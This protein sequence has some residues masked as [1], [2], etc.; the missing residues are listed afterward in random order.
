MARSRP[1]RKPVSLDALVA[2]GTHAITVPEAGK[3]LGISRSSAYDAAA[4]WRDTEGKEGLPTLLLG[5]RRLLV[6]V[7]ALRRML[8]TGAP[9]RS[10]SDGQR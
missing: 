7:P 1:A 9:P 8:E 6:P 10:T 4:R 3:L 5:E 2:S